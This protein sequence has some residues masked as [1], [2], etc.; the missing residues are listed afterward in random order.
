HRMPGRECNADLRVILESPDAGAM[1]GAR[2]DDD[3]G[4]PLRVDTDARRR[5]DAHQRVVDGPRERTR[6]EHHLVRKAQDRRQALAR[7]LHEGIAALAERVPEEHPALGEVHR[8]T[9]PAHPGIPRS[10]GLREE[11]RH[12]LG[13]GLLHALGEPLLRVLRA[14]LEHPRDFGREI[15]AARQVCC[16]TTGHDVPRFPPA[17]YSNGP[18]RWARA[19]RC[20]PAMRSLLCERCACPVGPWSHFAED[21]DVLI[22]LSDSTAM[23]PTSET[24]M[25]LS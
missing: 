21:E 20:A 4:T 8:V 11:S 24:T 13:E 17:R 25:T 14:C 10:R 9:A 7:V 3:V 5:R 18:C 15:V 23:V 19:P 2:I 22:F 1:P 12:V 16:R 6:V